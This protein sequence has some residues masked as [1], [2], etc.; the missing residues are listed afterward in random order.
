M[1]TIPFTTQAFSGL[2]PI[3]DG[4]RPTTYRR[5]GYRNQYVTFSATMVSLSI[6]KT[7]KNQRFK[8]VLGHWPEM[9][10]QVFDKLARQR[11]SDIETGHHTKSGTV[12]IGDFFVDYVLPQMES[13]NRDIKSV[14]TRWRRIMSDFAH[15]PIG[16]VTR[17]EV[18]AFLVKLSK[19]VKGSTVNRHLSLLSRIFS[20]AVSLDIIVKNPCSGVKKW[21]ENNI[22]QRVLSQTEMDLYVLEALKVDS[23]Q[24]RALLL[25]LFLGLR[26]G[27]VISM[28][29]S[30]VNL[31]SKQLYLPMTKNGRGYTVLLNEPAL[32]VIRQCLKT[33]TND[34]LFPSFVN[35]GEHISYPRSCHD[36]LRQLVMHAFP[37]SPSFNI[38]DLRRTYASR[39]LTLTG[40]ARLVQ[41]SLFHQSMAT[42]ERYAFHQSST[43]LQASQDT[44]LS[45]LTNEALEL[46]KGGK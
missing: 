12:R 5:E 4:G 46:L 7:F 17:L 27:N 21:P 26:I 25:S 9:S 14:K 22:R 19:S 8:E 38:H 20:A 35:D 34:W 24:S 16:A 43:L 32:F 30:M 2:L 10:F 6:A 42:T 44:A 31:S 36:K 29:R 13:H 37:D 15:R 1:K 28:Q 39:L 23:P 41:T 18:E 3:L 45:M 11:L 40:D 33:T